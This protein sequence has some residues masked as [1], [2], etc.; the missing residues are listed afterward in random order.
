MPIWNEKLQKWGYLYYEEVS[1]SDW[2]G[3]RRDKM[4]EKDVAKE[5]DLPPADETTDDGSIEGTD[6]TEDD[7]EDDVEGEDE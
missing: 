2:L 7:T 1:H 5:N 3:I 6:D 4:S